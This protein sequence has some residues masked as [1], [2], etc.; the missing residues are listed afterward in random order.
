MRIWVSVLL[1][2]STIQMTADIYSHLLDGDLKV[3]DELVFDKGT[4]TND[5]FVS[6]E[7]S[8]EKFDSVVKAIQ[9]LSELSPN[10]MRRLLETQTQRKPE[11][12]VTPLLRTVSE[13]E[14]LVERRDKK[15][16][17]TT[18]KLESESINLMNNVQGLEGDLCLD[19]DSKKN[20][21]LERVRTYDLLIR[22]P[23]TGEYNPS[24]LL[25]I[26]NAEQN[27]SKKS[28]HF[29]LQQ[30]LELAI[31]STSNCSSLAPH[32]SLPKSNLE[33]TSFKPPKRHGRT[34]K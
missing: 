20:G 28:T 26:N 6:K 30:L 11:E 1:G 27:S 22:R 34:K 3:K 21:G 7:S 29:H 5:N 2:H 4:K 32:G 25:T 19:S 9:A 12:H 13:D 24:K 23:I 15:V 10:E 18:Q 33:N 16:I 17:E 14:N 8:D 31:S